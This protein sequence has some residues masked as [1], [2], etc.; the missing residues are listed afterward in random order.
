MPLN[1]KTVFITGGTGGIGRPLVDMLKRAGASVEIYD[2]SKDG[3]LF[4]NLDRT[5]ERLKQNSPDI[6][7]NMAGFNDFNYCEDHDYEALINVN[8]LT[9]MRLTQAVL[10]EMRRRNSGQIVNIGSMTALIP[11]PHVTGYVA[12]KAGLKGF[13]D[14]LRRELSGTGISVTHVIPR[15]VKTAMNSGARA[16]INKRTNVHHDDP[17]KIAAIIMR[18]ILSK[19]AERRIGWPERF[20]AFLN[21]NFPFIID[22]GLQK[23]CKIGE[24]IL[25]EYS[26][27]TQHHEEMDN[28]NIIS[29]KTT[30]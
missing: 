8:M 2:R 13:N 25:A 18:A 21:A 27:Q 11:L 6:L 28:E 19:K 26:T 24:Q 3:D 12:A 30:A 16:E 17:E 29:I 7:I 23:N 14:A 15:A 9:P 4:D 10:P 20:F 22:Q 5:C 1:G